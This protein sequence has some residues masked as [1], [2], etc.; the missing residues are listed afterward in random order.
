MMSAWLRW[1][2]VLVCVGMLM[3]LQAAEKNGAQ[4]GAGDVVRVSVYGNP[5]LSLE[6]EIASNGKL[7]VPLLGDVALAGLGFDEAE[8]LLANKWQAAG[9]LQKPH[10]NILIV[11]SRSQ[12]VSVWGEVNRPGQY[13]LRVD[14]PLS[15][16]LAQA[17]GVSA[18]GAQRV[19]L[20]RHGKTTEI[21]LAKL[22]S[23]QQQDLLLEPGDQLHVKRQAMVY[24]YGEVARPGSYPL[25]EGMTVM[26]SIVVAGGF[27]SRADEDDI[28]L[29]QPGSKGEMEEKSV[30]PG[31]PVSA[32][33][34]IRVGESWF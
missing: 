3:P 33:A 13:P 31:D 12:M 24:V 11:E 34:V 22:A 27:S 17:G 4:L 19:E 20:L 28:V 5:D 16:M 29:Q 26:Q 21:D 10:V 6:A 18:G 2:C 15:A 9:V 14:T 23:G 1:C 32:D 8:Q 7:N 30:H 25:T